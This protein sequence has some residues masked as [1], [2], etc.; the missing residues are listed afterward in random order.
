MKY[1]YITTDWR[2]GEDSARVLAR[3]ESE[4]ASDSD[5]VLEL[6]ARPVGSPREPVAGELL[7][8]WVDVSTTYALFP[9][10]AATISEVYERFSRVGRFP[11][12]RP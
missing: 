3:H 4:P 7:S 12:D 9:T 1:K 10:T 8:V 11:A 2:P 5:E 6:V